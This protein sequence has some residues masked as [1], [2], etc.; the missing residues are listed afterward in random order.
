MVS[1]TLDTAQRLQLDI[2][3]PNQPAEMDG[4][5]ATVSEAAF[6]PLMTYI[7][8]HLEVSP[9]ALAAY[10]EANGEGYFDD[11]GNLI[12]AYDGSELVALW[13][14]NLE[15]VDGAGGVVTHEGGNNGYSAD[16]AEFVYPALENLP[17]ELWLAPVRDGQA[18]MIRAVRVR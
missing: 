2:E 8:L 3:T 5:T 12:E 13:A 1:F 4:L 11:Q 7:T 9:E 10:K 16:W 18:D 15:L 6:S 14:L 17:E